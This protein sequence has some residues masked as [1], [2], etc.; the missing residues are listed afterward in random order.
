VDARAEWNDTG[1][2]VVAGQSYRYTAEGTW[3]DW[4]IKT[5]ADGFEPWLMAPL[6]SRRRVKDA[7]WFRL[8]GAVDRDAVVVLG[9]AGQFVAP[10]SG[11]LYCYA[12]DWLS[13]LGNNKGRVCLRVSRVVA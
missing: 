1:F 5:D 8:I 3:T 11:R 12:N 9:K 10:A 6:R 4:F 2:D 13:K 7:P